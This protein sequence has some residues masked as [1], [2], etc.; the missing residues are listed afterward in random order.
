M[1]APT[2]RRP[3]GP[4]TLV[5]IRTDLRRF[6]GY[7]FDRSLEANEADGT[8]R[9][10]EILADKLDGLADLAIFDNLIDG[11]LPGAVHKPFSGRTDG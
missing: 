6:A 1:A 9:R 7:V 8:R 5:E 10:L 3:E 2:D 4:P 11:P